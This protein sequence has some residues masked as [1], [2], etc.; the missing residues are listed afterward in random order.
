MNEALASKVKNKVSFKVI[1]L[2][3]AFIQKF[4]SHLKI[5]PHQSISFL[6]KLA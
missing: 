3:F 5:L 1:F 2:P 4:V 6:I